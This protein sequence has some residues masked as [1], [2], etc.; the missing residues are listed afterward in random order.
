MQKTKIEWVKNPDGSQGYSWNPIRGICPVGCWYCYARKIYQR[1]KMNPKLSFNLDL[2]EIEKLQRFNPKPGSRIFVCSTMELFH[3]SI[4]K[5]WR[6]DIFTIIKANLKLTFIIL[7]KMPENI[8]RPMPDNV[9]LGVT[10]TG[11]DEYPKKNELMKIQAKVRFMSYEPILSPLPSVSCYSFDWI[12]L[13]RLTGYGHKYDPQNE[14]I[15]NFVGMSRALG[16]PIFL[17]NNLKDI[18]KRPLIQEFPK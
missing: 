9:H 13:G 6:E 4:L 17:K 14:L 16:I 1:F 11:F 3:P 7:T 5:E 8:D 15:N 18:W 2:H 12:I 10:I